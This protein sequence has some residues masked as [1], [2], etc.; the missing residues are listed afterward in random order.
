MVTLK[1]IADEAGVSTVTVSNVIHKKYGKVSPEKI[2]LINSI[3]A[4]YNYVPNANARSLASKKSK[5]I[6]III[7]YVDESDN[8]LSSPYNMEIVG[9]LESEIRGRNYFT[10]IR[11][12][13]SV[14]EAIPIIKSWNVDGAIILGASEGDVELTMKELSLPIIFVDSYS[15][16]NH[17]NVGVEDE[18]GGY[19]A[20]RFLISNGHKKIWF[21]GPELSEDGKGV[22][23]ERFRGYM[24]ALKESNL[25]GEKKW[26]YAHRTQYNCGIDVGKAIAF[27]KD[28]PTAVFATSDIVALGIT[29]GLRLSGVNV[30]EDISVVG[31]DNLPEGQYA[32]PKLTTVCQNIQEKGKLVAKT[33]FDVLEKDAAREIDIKNYRLDEKIGVELVERNSVRSL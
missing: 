14:T 6:G 8:F 13:S 26:V 2:D 31:F 19:L 16:C 28:R 30:P 11:S 21:V 7:P 10:M 3:I 5:I 17:I 12:A 15:D 32:Y 20:T 33:L 29:E 23:E 9:V 25:Q 24:R 18:K 1:T 22:I 27:E 4:K